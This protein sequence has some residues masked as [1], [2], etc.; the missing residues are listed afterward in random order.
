MMNRDPAGT[1]DAPVTQMAPGDE[2]VAII[3]AVASFARGPLVLQGVTT[4]SGS[5]SSPSSAG[6]SAT[7]PRAAS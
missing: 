7:R 2:T 5:D 4:P 6:R 3:N 1:L